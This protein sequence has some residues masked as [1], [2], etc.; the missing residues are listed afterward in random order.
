[1]MKAGARQLT[2][3][4]GTL[5]P[6]PGLAPASWG[7][8]FEAERSQR[9]G[10]MKRFVAFIALALIAFPYICSAG[11]VSVRGYTRRD[12]TYVAPYHRSSPDSTVTNNYDFGGNSNPYTGQTGQNYYRSN[13]TSPYFQTG[14]ASSPSERAHRWFDLVNTDSG[15]N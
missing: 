12:G 9:G 4:M 14:P 3:S 11:D 2:F 8:F 1:M 13:P 10:N 15:N 5:C 7:F 6:A